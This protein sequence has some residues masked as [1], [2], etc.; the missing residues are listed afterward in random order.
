MVASC[1]GLVV[2]SA[3]VRGTVVIALG[4]AFTWVV[5]TL[6]SNAANSSMGGDWC[7]DRHAPQR[8]NY[9]RCDTEHCPHA[10]A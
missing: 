4:V 7:G 2:V 5:S 1:A 10:C 6:Y 3:V 8:E 9:D